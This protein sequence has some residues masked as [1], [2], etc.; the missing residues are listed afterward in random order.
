MLERDAP[1]TQVL[2]TA[3]ERQRDLRKLVELFV[4]GHEPRVGASHEVIADHDSA[5]YRR[6]R[7]HPAGRLGPS[8]ARGVGPPCR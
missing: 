3:Q 2:D 4:T 5:G 6:R 8:P 1:R 7:E